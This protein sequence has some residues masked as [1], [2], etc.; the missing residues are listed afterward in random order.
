MIYEWFDRNY[1]RYFACAFRISGSL[2][3]WGKWYA[4]THRPNWI[5]VL[6]AI[7]R[8][9]SHSVQMNCGKYLP[10]TITK[11]V[12]G[13]ENSLKNGKR[14]Y[15]LSTYWLWSMDCRSDFNCSSDA[16]CSCNR[17][18]VR[19]CVCVWMMIEAIAGVLHA[20]WRKTQMFKIDHAVLRS[21]CAGSICILVSTISSL[22]WANFSIWI[23][24]IKSTAVRRH[25]MNL[26]SRTFEWQSISFVSF[27]FYRMVFNCRLIFDMIFH[28]KSLK[29]KWN[30]SSH[31]QEHE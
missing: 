11:Q 9:L 27:S 30:V 24:R 31:R 25:S 4:H 19:S 29:Q 8:S 3:E 17:K 18:Y 2:N 23:V 26:R 7:S 6:L 16:H 28:F 5:I 10:H 1:G 22:K 13:K 14:Y 15:L 21:L 20:L 12:N